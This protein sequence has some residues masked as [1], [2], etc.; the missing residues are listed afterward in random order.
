[1][2]YEEIKKIAPSEAA[3]PE[4]GVTK[5]SE[6]SNQFSTK[7]ADLAIFHLGIIEGLTIEH[8][9]HIDINYHVN[10]LIEYIREV[11]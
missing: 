7:S 10:R 8:P 2:T 9:N 3:T 6:P 11:K 4:Q 5:V 1:M